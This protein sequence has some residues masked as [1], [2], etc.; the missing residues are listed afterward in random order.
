MCFS[1]WGSSCYLGAGIH[2][3]TAEAAVWG[4]RSNATERVWCGFKELGSALPRM[5]FCRCGHV[6]STCLLCLSELAF[7]LSEEIWLLSGALNSVSWEGPECL[8]RA[9][10]CRSHRGK[11]TLKVAQVSGAIQVHREAIC[12]PLSPAMLHTHN[13]DSQRLGGR[14]AESG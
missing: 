2:I 14:A 12:I 3:A 9:A 8:F 6:K 5:L 4:R 10:R 11:R 7:I 13:W 1:I